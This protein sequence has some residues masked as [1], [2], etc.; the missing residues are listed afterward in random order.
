MPR[1]LV[2]GGAGFLGA[3]LTRKLVD[4]GNGE[5]FALVR[6]GGTPSPHPD[7]RT[8]S[9]D[10]CDRAQTVAA[11]HT[12]CPDVVF[13]CAMTAGHPKDS[14]GRLQALSTA[15]NGTAHL[16]EAALCTGVQRFVHM[17]S[18]LVYRQQPRPVR[19]CDPIQPYS[20]RGAAKAA[21]SLWLQQCAMLCA[22]PL[23]ELRIFSVYGPGEPAHRFIPALLRAARDAETIL[24]NPAPAHDFVFIDDVVDAC[25]LAEQ[26]SLPA[27][28]VFNIGSGRTWRND[29]V[30]RIASNATGRDIAFDNGAYPPGPADSG[31]WQ[32]DI[33]EAAARLSWKPRHSLEEGLRATYQ[34]LTQ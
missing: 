31:Y 13:H 8:I 23:V 7:A 3:R 24:L 4:R 27:G 2:T 20:F 18:F 10:L 30:L 6:P 32:A 15:V 17:G 19:E 14:A 34:C 28:A 21:A 29:E 5:V 25:L 16:A 26:S 11:V 33:S 1:Y 9:A 12:A 22:L